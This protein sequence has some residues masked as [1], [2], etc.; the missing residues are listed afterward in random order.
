[1][2]LVSGC[3]RKTLVRG[4][5]GEYFYWYMFRACFFNHMSSLNENSNEV[6]VKKVDFTKKCNRKHAALNLEHWFSN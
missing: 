4:N 1:M 3:G 6:A 2:L 5:T